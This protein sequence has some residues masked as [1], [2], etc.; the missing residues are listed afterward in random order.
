MENKPHDTSSADVQIGVYTEKIEQL[1]MDMK[2]VRHDDPVFAKMRSLL[3]KHVF[4]RRRLLNYLQN[5][6]YVRYR[7]AMEFI[8]ADRKAS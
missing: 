1:E 4:E 6:D 8:N 5:S 2:G 7:R 3:I